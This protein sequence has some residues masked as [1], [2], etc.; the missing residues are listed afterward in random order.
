MAAG[1]TG[2]HPSAELQ[3]EQICSGTMFF[4]FYF[5]LGRGFYKQETN[6]MCNTIYNNQFKIVFTMHLFY[7]N[8]Q[9]PYALEEVGGVD[10]SI[11]VWLQLL[12]LR[13]HHWGAIGERTF[14]KARKQNRN[15]QVKRLFSGKSWRLSISPEFAS[16]IVNLFNFLLRPS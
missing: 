4:Y 5:F 13:F 8:S 3:K 15:T 2:C 11:L 16:K 14:T 10:S 1:I 7:P 9:F 6:K 12:A